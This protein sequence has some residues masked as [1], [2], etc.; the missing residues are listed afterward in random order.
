[1]RRPPGAAHINHSF[2]AE[3]G[4][5]SIDSA[6]GKEGV[7]GVPQQHRRPESPMH[8]ISPARRSTDQS[9]NIP[10]RISPTMSF[11][12]RYVPSIISALTTTDHRS[13][14]ILRSIRLQILKMFFPPSHKASI[15]AS[16]VLR[17]HC[18][19][20]SRALRAA[21]Q[22]GVLDG[23]RKSGSPVSRLGPPPGAG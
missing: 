17:Y 14:V 23:G 6:K 15:T 1:M 5:L 18:D 10:L 9:T 16:G 4:R 20:L 13:A 8:E 19:R 2:T 11:L 22:G 12:F 21:S 7:S 3:R